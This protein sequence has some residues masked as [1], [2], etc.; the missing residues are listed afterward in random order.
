MWEK[1][2]VEYLGLHILGRMFESRQPNCKV[3]KIHISSRPPSVMVDHG[4]STLVV[5]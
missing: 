1:L 2:K 4:L 3:C 5:C